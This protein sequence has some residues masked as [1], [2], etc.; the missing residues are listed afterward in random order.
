MDESLR[1]TEEVIA[2]ALADIQA[3]REKFRAITE[4]LE[5]RTYEEEVEE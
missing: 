1:Q 2:Q 5:Q 3:T 4:S